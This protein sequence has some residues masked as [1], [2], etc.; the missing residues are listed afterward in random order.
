M[1]TNQPFFHPNINIATKQIVTHKVTLLEYLTTIETWRH[2]GLAF[3]LHTFNVDSGYLFH[4]LNCSIEDKL[5]IKSSAKNTNI[6]QLHQPR[7]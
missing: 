5:L 6:C 4:H 2:T 3:R 1:L 7:K